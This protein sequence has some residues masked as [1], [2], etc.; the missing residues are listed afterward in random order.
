V[1][2]DQRGLLT[3]RF[4]IRRVPATVRRDGNRL[5]IEEFPPK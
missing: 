4:G 2:F 5:L 3:Q 1:Y